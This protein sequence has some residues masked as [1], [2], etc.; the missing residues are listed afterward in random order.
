M[1]MTGTGSTRTLDLRMRDEQGKQVGAHHQRL[2]C[3]GRP[4]RLLHA[5]LRRKLSSSE[6]TPRWA[7][8]ALTA[9]S[10]PTI[11]NISRRGV[12]LV[13]AEG[14]IA[15]GS[16]KRD[17]RMRSAIRKGMS[18]ASWTAGEPGTDKSVPLRGC[19]TLQSR[20]PLLSV[21]CYGGSKL[22]VTDAPWS[23]NVGDGARMPAGVRGS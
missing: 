16:P 2:L 8:G 15:S 7:D 12:L 17:G 10:C 6:R 18:R 9:Q 5:W 14:G 11:Y 22:G 23:E 21:F 19:S 4:L 13:G 3:L 20:P 1:M